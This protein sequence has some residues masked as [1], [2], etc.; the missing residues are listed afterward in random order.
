MKLFEKIPK[1]WRDIGAIAS[2]IFTFIATVMG[3]AGFSLNGI[4]H[5]WIRFAV[6]F[7]AFVILVFAV[8]LVIWQRAKRGI[9]LRVRNITV[10]IR[11]EISSLKCSIKKSLQTRLDASKTF[12]LIVGNSTKSLTNVMR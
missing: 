8:H 10:E 4:S 6:I 3:V 11:Q 7:S 5:W 9:V 12:V 2:A 1:S